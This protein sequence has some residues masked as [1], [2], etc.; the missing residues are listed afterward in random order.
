MRTMRPNL[1]EIEVRGLY[2]RQAFIYDPWSILTESRA[3]EAVLFSRGFHPEK[4]FSRWV[5]GRAACFAK[6]SPRIQPG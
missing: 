5:L 2:D 3:H 6:S 4:G 1:S